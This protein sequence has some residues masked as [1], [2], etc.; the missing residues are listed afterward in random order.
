MDSLSKD[1]YA[2]VAKAINE[3][4]ELAASK[5]D[6]KKEE[7]LELW[8]SRVSSPLQAK[9]SK[10]EKKPA[11]KAATKTAA[12]S[13]APVCAYEFKKGA[14]AG[15]SCTSKAREGSTFC[16]K[17]KSQEGKDSPSEEKKKTPAKKKGESKEKE[18][19]VVKKMNEGKSKLAVNKNKHGNYE[20][21]ETHLVLDKTSKEVYGKQVG[22]KVVS[23]TEEDIE[24]C[25]K[26]N[27]KYKLPESLSSSKDKDE[28]EDDEKE[29]ED[30]D[31]DEEEDEDEDEEEEDDE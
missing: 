8:N 25:K 17:H 22:D 9:A 13:D 29:K 15:T 20:H 16:N 14:N 24:Q 12:S 2:V 10:D 27:F 19:P 7:L 30:E 23:L 28:E 1:L 31:E 3:F 26:Y 5:C 6:V 11:K 18:A 21:T 4:A